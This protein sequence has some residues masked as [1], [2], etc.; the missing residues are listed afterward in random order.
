MAKRT[1][2][3][4]SVITPERQVLDTAA[5]QVIIP[6]HDGLIGILFNRA[7]LLCE[8][9]KGTLRI[10]TVGEGEKQIPI[11][12]GFAQVLD[13]EVIVLTERAGEEASG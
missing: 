3:K 13:N 6:A 1:H 8:L 9:G 4:C 5:T 7:P 2:I 11:D 10:N 12:G